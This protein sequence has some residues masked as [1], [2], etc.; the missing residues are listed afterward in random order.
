MLSQRRKINWRIWMSLEKADDYQFFKRLYKQQNL[1]RNL[2]RKTRIRIRRLENSLV[3][4]QAQ[5]PRLMI[6]FITI[7]NHNPLGSSKPKLNNIF[8]QTWNQY[9]QLW[10]LNITIYNKIIV[11]QPWKGYIR[12]QIWIDTY[13]STDFVCVLL[14]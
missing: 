6:H 4:L 10:H 7:C 9:T 12:G 14:D 5:S 11:D 8:T 13:R 2:R 1:K 3:W